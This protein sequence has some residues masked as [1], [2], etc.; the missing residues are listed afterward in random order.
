VTVRELVRTERFRRL[1]HA[2]VRR[3]RSL[4]AVRSHDVLSLNRPPD[5]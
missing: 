2:L 4:D 1:V 5:W 3:E